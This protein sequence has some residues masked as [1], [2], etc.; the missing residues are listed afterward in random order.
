MGGSADLDPAFKW[1]CNRANGGDFLILRASGKD[2]YDA[3]VQ[4]LCHANS[5]ATLIIPNKSAA[6]DAFVAST[7]HNAEAI[8]IAPGEQSNYLKYWQDTPVQS[9]INDRIRAGVTVGASSAG[10][11]LLGEYVFTASHDAAYSQEA[12]ANPYY[13]GV[14]LASGFL[15]VPYM[16]KTITEEHLGAHDAPGRLVGFM[17]RTLQDGASDTIRGIVVDEK[18]ALLVD[19]NGAASLVGPGNVYFFRPKHKPEVC[20][21][22][23]PLTFRDIQVYKI[24]H[25]GSFNLKDWTG[26][27]GTWYVLSAVEGHLES[28]NGSVY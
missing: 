7:I 14:T 6:E 24:D 22:G 13:D 9:A 20:V 27:G 18:N 4:N 5:V 12:L 23:Q 2:D 3:Y 25:N 28:S 26:S 17:A 8:F 11:A 19:E 16:E 15:R 10:L 21:A 1:I